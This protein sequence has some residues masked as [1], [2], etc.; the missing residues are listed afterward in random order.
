MGKS[1]MK[2]TP[3]KVVKA[4]G[5]A[6]AATKKKPLKEGEKPLRQGNKPLQEGKQT[7]TKQLNKKNLEKLGELTLGERVALAAEEETEE[8]AVETLKEGMSKIDHSK[9]WGQHNT[10]LK[11][12]PKAEQDAHANKTKKE[13]GDAVCL[14]LLK[15]NTERFQHHSQ[16]V[17]G[18]SS[19]LQKERWV[20]QK[21]ILKA[22]S[23]DE[24]DAH[25][26][27]G[28]ILARQCKKTPG[29]W[30]Y[31][32]TEDEEKIRKASKIKSLKQGQEYNPDE[33]DDEEF[34]SMWQSSSH[35]QMH[36][37]CDDKGAGKG[38]A[39]GSG[40]ALK[41]GSAKGKKRGLLAL[42]DKEEEEEEEEKEQNPEDELKDAMK[43][44]K[45]ARDL[46]QSQSTDLEDALVKASPL[47]TKEGK[48]KGLEQ[49]QE[50]QKVLQQLK[51]VCSKEHLPLTKLKDLLGGSQQMSQGFKGHHQG[52]Q[53]LGQQS[54][55]QS[56]FE[57]VQQ[58]KDNPL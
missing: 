53:A 42:K 46:T 36:R 20:S 34:A 44:A 11:K 27:S 54:S 32:D 41:E 49:Q 50:L 22:W 58:V 7:K 1:A 39:K 57:K 51:A 9:A 35:S 13:K 29:V 31:C 30:E 4:K 12:Q 33:N 25:L 3:L 21:T 38:G 16:E 55:F 52:A 28:R 48:R 14:W 56:P 15:K 37:L 6:K 40:K 5:K 2:K 23:E 43:K 24:L 19:V 17:K 8:A 18:S 10:W 26:E 45:R 47:L